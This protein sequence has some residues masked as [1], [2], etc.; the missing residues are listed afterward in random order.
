M[1]ARDEHK[2]DAEPPEEIAESK[3]SRTLAGLEVCE[4]EEPLLVPHAAREVALGALLDDVPGV[5]EEELVVERAVY[6]EKSGVLLG[7]HKAMEG[8]KS[9]LRNMGDHH[10]YEWAISGVIQVVGR[11]RRR[12]RAEPGHCAAGQ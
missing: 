10:V 3:R 8:R 2:R 5:Y 4:L 7:L 1:D 11:H 6:G 12:R 9:E